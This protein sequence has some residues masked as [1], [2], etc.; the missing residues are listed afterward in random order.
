MSQLDR[1]S[2]RRLLQDVFFVADGPHDQCSGL[3]LCA[4]EN[5][6]GDSDTAF[7]YVKTNSFVRTGLIINLAGCDLARSST[8]PLSSWSKRWSS[9]HLLSANSLGVG[10]HLRRAK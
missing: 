9:S 7:K 6:P 2:M 1:D 4:L 3:Q 5:N 10:D 8:P